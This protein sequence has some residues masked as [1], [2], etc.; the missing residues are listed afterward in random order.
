MFR[1][2]GQIVT[3]ECL[4]RD[5]RPAVVMECLFRKVMD[6]NL[7]WDVYLERWWIDCYQGM[8][9]FKGSDILAFSKECLLRDLG[10]TVA[11]EYLLGRNTEY[12]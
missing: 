8:L 3:R 10:L 6:K 5:R 1:N 12:L 7:L 4:L 9:L 2:G 11:Q